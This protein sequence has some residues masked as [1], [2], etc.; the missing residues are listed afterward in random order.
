M[1][2]YNGNI[3]NVYVYL[4]YYLNIKF[5]CVIYDKKYMFCRNLSEF[6]I[7]FKIFK[8][9]IKSSKYKLGC[10]RIYCVWYEMVRYSG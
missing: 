10:G 2:L 7:I 9:I 1:V 6:I 4:R 3:I 8:F 5:D